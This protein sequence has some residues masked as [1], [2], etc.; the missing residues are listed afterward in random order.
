[1]RNGRS[2][3]IDEGDR[4]CRKKSRPFKGTIM[5]TCIATFTKAAS[6]SLCQS[7]FSKFKTLF[8]GYRSHGYMNITSVPHRRCSKYHKSCSHRP[9][10]LLD[11]ETVGSVEQ[12]YT[13]ECADQ[14]HRAQSSETLLQIRRTSRS[15]DSL[16][17]AES[18]FRFGRVCALVFFLIHS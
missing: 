3:I 10:G 16:R 17:N 15:G 2:Q 13:E 18:G 1:M 14:Y 11:H 5:Y 9:V 4:V 8:C 6:G 12:V 7:G